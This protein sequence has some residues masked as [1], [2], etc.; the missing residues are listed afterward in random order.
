MHQAKYPSEDNIYTWITDEVFPDII[1]RKGREDKPRLALTNTGGIR[2]DIFKGPFTRDS[3]YAVSPFMSGFRYIKDVPYEAAAK[4]IH[5]LNSGGTIFEEHGLDVRFLTFPEQMFPK[6]AFAVEEDTEET[7]QVRLELRS[8]RDEPT[9]TSGYTTKDDIG[10]DGDDTV[11]AAVKS[12]P[13]PNVIQGKIAFPEDGDP[14]TVDFVFLDFT[15][16]WIIPA[17]NF[18]GFACSDASV[19]KYMEGS[20]TSLMAD[21][22]SENWKG[23]C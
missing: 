5:I 15:Q 6:P 8:L 23:D 18:A 13:Q 12:Y 11:H 1:T 4:V 7:E 3:T 10:D 19:D 16:P 9:L 22:I 21:W 17:L 20:L 14:E 2:F